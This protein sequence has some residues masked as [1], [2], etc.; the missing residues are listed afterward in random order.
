MEHKGRVEYLPQS[1]GLT[2]LDFNLWGPLENTP[3]S[4]TKHWNVV[5][6]HTTPRIEEVCHTM[7]YVVVNMAMALMVDNSGMCDH[8]RNLDSNTA[9]WGGN[10][11]HGCLF[12]VF[13][14]TAPSE[15][16]PPHSQDF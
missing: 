15:S 6:H 10:I 16:G 2:S 8:W 14:A 7:L 11:D 9:G 5:C 1:P 12:V 13:G 4:E 3:G